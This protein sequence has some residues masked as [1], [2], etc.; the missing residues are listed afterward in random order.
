M[1]RWIWLVF[2]V[3]AGVVLV[4]CG[5]GDE[6][7]AVAVVLEPV[8]TTG[9]DPF[10]DSVAVR[11]ATDLPDSAGAATAGTETSGTTPGLYGGTQDAAV[12]DPDQ[13]VTFLAQNPDKGAAWA[14]VL[15]IRPQDIESYVAR[16][17]PVVLT[18]DTRV[19]NH[20]YRN[21]R[22]TA[23]QSVLQAG[24]AVLVD[25]R[26]VPRVKCGCGNPLTG[27]DT[28]IAAPAGDPWPGYQPDQVTTITPGARPVTD[29][30]LVDI[31]TGETYE[32]PTGGG[33]DGGGD[34][35][36]G[37]IHEVDFLNRFYITHQPEEFEEGACSF[38]EVTLVDGTSGGG[39][40]GAD[41]YD[42]KV[43]YAD[44]TGDGEDEA[45]VALRFSGGSFHNTN[46]MIFGMRD[47]EAVELGC[48]P[49]DVAT[50][51]DDSNG[52]IGWSAISNGSI[53]RVDAVSYER[54]LKVFRDGRFVLESSEEVPVAQFHAETGQ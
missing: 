26:G 38:G 49:G 29:L 20:G 8:N 11:E 22:A 45:L 15:G 50:V 37:S 1:R 18:T 19:T 31:T 42:V 27:P 10:T 14:G 39:Q 34:G 17:T 12:C 41:Q 51:A 40:L 43:T 30:T 5:G 33:G 53:S 16:L 2:V 32:Q 48:V 54:V 13:L 21:G 52:L 24:T 4:A 46:N 36:G 47:G 9:T 7:S 3:L 25:A 28:E 44:V 23:F 6:A 35:G